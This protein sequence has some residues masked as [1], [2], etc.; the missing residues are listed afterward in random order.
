[1]TLQDGIN[2][3]TVAEAATLSARSG[4]NVRLQDGGAVAA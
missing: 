1:V 2:A 4:R 3:L